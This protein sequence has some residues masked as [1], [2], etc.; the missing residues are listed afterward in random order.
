MTV[1]LAAYRKS[2]RGG[3]R[4]YSVAMRCLQTIG[5]TP[6]K[7]SFAD[8]CERER[9]VIVLPGFCTSPRVIFTLRSEFF[10]SENR[11]AV[12]KKE[13]IFRAVFW[14]CRTGLN[15]RPLPYQGSA[16]PLSYGSVFNS[17]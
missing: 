4:F 12:S 3:T 1:T 11:K 10:T 17:L 9:I 2:W 7:R 8:G 16:L 6:R 13:L 5:A 15:C 14:C